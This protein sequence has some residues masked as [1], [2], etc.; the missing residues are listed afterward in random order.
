MAKALTGTQVEMTIKVKHSNNLIVK[1]R[2]RN[3][4]G[5][6]GRSDGG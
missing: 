5:R 2:M 3:F 4:W 1:D 6:A